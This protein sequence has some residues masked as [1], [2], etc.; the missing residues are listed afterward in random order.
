[1]CV[2]VCVCVCVC[3]CA[4]VLLL[5]LNNLELIVMKLG[6]KTMANGRHYNITA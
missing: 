4:C 5:Q 2:C 3:D 1:M 6:I